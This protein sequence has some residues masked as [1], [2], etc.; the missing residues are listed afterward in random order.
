MKLHHIQ[1]SILRYVAIA[2]LA[3]SFCDS[4]QA[5]TTL[6]A[7]YGWGNAARLG[8]WTCLFVT[9]RVPDPVPIEATLQI[10]GTYSTGAA[11]SISEP[12]V[13]ESRPRLYLVL[14]PL[15]A[16]P[17]RLAVTLRRQSNGKTLATQILLDPEAFTPAG[18]VPPIL[19]SA[20]SGLIG[21]GGNVADAALLQSQLSQTGLTAGIL[22]EMK[23]PAA[24]VGYE[25][26]AALLLAA[27]DFQQLDGDQQRAIV[28][29]VAAGGNLI[30]IP[31]SNPI[32]PQIPLDIL[33]PCDIGTNA[34]VP[35]P[36]NSPATQPS[37][38]N[39]RQL[40]PLPGAEPIQLLSGGDSWTAYTQRFGLG[41]VL[42]LPADISS[43]QF[44][45]SDQTIAFWRTILSSMLDVPGHE[46][47][48]EITV[49][50]S[51]EDIM[52]I[53]PKMADAIGRGPR[54]TQAARHLLDLLDASSPEPVGAWRSFFL[55]LIGIGAL[56]GPLDS[57]VSLRMGFSRRHWTT[58]LGWLAILVGATAYGV[59]STSP[60]DRQVSSFRLIDQADGKVV[61]TTDLLALRSNRA[62][63]LPLQLNRAEWWEPAN[64]SAAN[65]PPNRFLEFNCQEDQSGCRP[66][67]IS[68]HPGDPQSL[69]GQTIS[70]SPPILTVALKIQNSAAVGTLTN[71][72]DS[73]IQNIQIA[74]APGNGSINGTLAPGATIQVNCPLTESP[75]ALEGL[76]S[77][78]LD[79]TP[80]R[81]DRIAALIRSGAVA[82]VLGQTLDASPGRVI[83][84]P[85][86]YRQWRVVRAV[87]A[88]R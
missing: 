46:T 66:E 71:L 85:A 49:S 86:D 83:Q 21:I 65:F 58:L 63:T 19:L 54:E 30:L 74:A 9:V 42:V 60:A 17:T 87:A 61:A 28:D 75:V 72:S 73:P 35:L 25:G 3:A 55:W 59:T 79:I 56:L 23:L 20:N 24:S 26:I 15:N 50:D 41:R 29:W 36:A 37:Q 57:I 31:P 88:A 14:F 10:E 1:S 8:R 62:E 5:Q 68:L 45:N 33:L 6:K 11:L 4:A 69:R 27:P 77:D 22:N 52:P 13:V 2:F 67:Q 34:V 48:T 70:A 82:C 12:M 18:R 51:Q 47:I 32:P 53:G 76:P 7:V 64:Q 16:D 39:G 40:H 78:A 80:D 43:L 84:E 44:S 38:L 81:T